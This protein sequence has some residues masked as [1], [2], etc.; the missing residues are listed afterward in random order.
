MKTFDVRASVSGD[1]YDN[2]ILGGGCVGYAA[3]EG[4]R[5]RGERVLLIEPTGQLL[6]EGSRALEGDWGGAGGEEGED[7]FGAR[8][9][10]RAWRDA[11]A[12]H[13]A[14][15]AGASFDPVFAEIA[16][17][18]SLLSA[19]GRVAVWFYVMPVAAELAGG[20]IRSVTVATKS[21][22]RVVRARRWIDASESGVLAALASPGGTVGG[23]RPEAT[24]RSLMLRSPDWSRHEEA[25]RAFCARAGARLEGTIHPHERRLRW[26]PGEGVSWQEEIVGLLRRF[27][28][29]V[30]AGP[31]VIV[32]HCAAEVF[33]V[34]GASAGGVRAGLVAENL[35]VLSPALRTGR[36]VSVADRFELG[37]AAAR[38][39]PAV[40]ARGFEREEF[41]E[42]EPASPRVVETVRCDVVVAGTGTAGAVAAVAA[43]R[44]GR[45]VCALDFASFPGGVGTGGGITGYFYGAEGGLQAV[46]DE[47]TAGMD[48]LLEGASETT[49]RWH[50]ESKKLALLACFARHG[51]VFH[52]DTLLCEV[53]KSDA[54]TVRAVLAATARGLVRFEAEAF[55]DSTGDGDL[56]V[57]AG[58]AFETGR[59]GDGRTLAY[60]QSVFLLRHEGGRLVTA[61]CNF[62]AGWTDPTD[63]E[64]FSRARLQGVAQHWRERW[65][66]EDRPF[67]ISPLPG[68]RQ[69]RRIVTDYTLTFRD[70]VDR[71]RFDDKIG[72]AESIADTHSVDYEFEHDEAVFFYW[73]CRLFRHRLRTGLPYR[74]LLPRGL[75][76]V[77]IACRAAGIDATAFYAVRM[78]RDMQRLGEAAGVAAARACATGRGAR[79]VDPA[80]LREE[81]GETETVEDGEEA[82]GSGFGA[83]EAEAAFTGRPPGLHL[84]RTY[85]RPEL[86]RAWLRR[87]LAGGDGTRSFYAACVFAMW[88]CAEAEPRLLAAIG[89]REEG[90][91]PAA[92]NT[93]AHGQEID[94]PF[95]LLAVI[96]LRRAGT[97]RCVGALAEL[98][99]REDN[100][101]NVRTAVALT[102]ERLVERG[103]ITTEDG[104]GLVDRLV[105]HP[106]TD[107]ML[108][109]SRSLWRTLRGAPQ[110]TLRNDTGADTREDQSWQLHLIVARVRARAGLAAHEEARVFFAD[111]RAY[112]RRA[113]SGWTRAR[114][115]RAPVVSE[116]GEIVVR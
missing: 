104:V 50:H 11:L 114:A 12:A 33:P 80:A 76:N 57:R 27:R 16:A 59:E 34:Y 56:C 101:L 41:G 89:Q 102:V 7:L 84:W 110:I 62:D 70:L 32:T 17:A 112:V 83:G 1:V 109:P 40:A 94:I 98:A 67:A 60:S 21:G 39:L 106:I 37:A 93:G 18:R 85:R 71:S 23:R 43:A 55:I 100:V 72:E 88:E 64:D 90:L 116:C 74:M 107:R 5:A 49:H 8:P 97:A 96:L 53:E 54:G 69:S 73:V 31:E 82:G 10:C 44:A 103:A 51:A 47:E 36:I 78:Q 52:G 113:F 19:G 63:C 42:G 46:I 65:T 3:A 30:C 45:R 6:W 111:S 26:S 20:R 66:D 58:A 87:H 81:L 79:G 25:A 29:E 105:A 35:H 68:I 28:A 91:P 99:E 24:T 38:D 108:T 15:G 115:E 4:L 61:S 22:F 86:H 92:D 48:R 14:A 77:W 95:W 2:V 75:G 13:G 9:A